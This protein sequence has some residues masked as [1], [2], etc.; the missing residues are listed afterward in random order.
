V[1]AVI[2]PEDIEYRVSLFIETQELNEY[3][4]RSHIKDTVHNIKSRIPLS[5]TTEQIAHQKP[6]L[7]MKNGLLDPETG[8]LIPHTKEYFDTAQ[9]PF[10]YLPK[11]KEEPTVWLSFLD[12][13]FNANKNLIDFLQ[14]IFGYCLT[15]DTS[16]HAAF[17][18][19]S[20]LKV[21]GKSTCADVLRK[22]VGESNS[23]TIPISQLASG[24][25]AVMA[26]VGKRL[27]ISDEMDTRYLESS[28]VSSIV[29]GEPITVDVKYQLPITIRPKVKFVFTTNTLPN[30]SSPTGMTRRTY[31]IPFNHIITEEERIYGLAEKIIEK[32]SSLIL[33]WAIQGLWRLKEREKGFVVPNEVIYEIT[34]YKQEVSSADAFLSDRDYVD[35]IPIIDGGEKR[36]AREIYGT[37]PGRDVSGSGYL[38]YCHES[39]MK[40]MSFKRFCRELSRFALENPQKVSKSIDH[41]QY[42]YPGIALVDKNNQDI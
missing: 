34:E 5:W 1:Y 14:E 31:P 8:A 2:P 39:K 35:F 4:T 7:N 20:E 6:Y 9:I 12:K 33:N 17:F 25:H 32:E 26:L 38:R 40:A 42:Y 11:A 23:S 16:L 3:R 19:Y 10:E 22:L 28:I 15:P 24:K 13:V 29:S 36:T 18:F 30:Y 37:E 21:T 41:N 27:N